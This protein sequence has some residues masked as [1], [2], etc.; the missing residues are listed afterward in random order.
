MTVTGFGAPGLACPL[1]PEF[2]PAEALGVGDKAG[3]GALGEGE[4]AGAGARAG[5][6]DAGAT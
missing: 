5:E 1:L 4:T 3:A 6:E 2:D